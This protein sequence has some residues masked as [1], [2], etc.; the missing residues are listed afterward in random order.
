MKQKIGDTRHSMMVW[1][2]VLLALLAVVLIASGVGGYALFIVG[3]M[4]MM[5]AMMWMMTGGP[6][7]EPRDGTTP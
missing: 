3:C 7:S 2:C 5:G 6:G 1:G 4:V